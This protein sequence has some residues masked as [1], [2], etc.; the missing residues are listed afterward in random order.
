MT[1]RISILVQ[2]CVVIVTM[3]TLSL[4]Y[5]CVEMMISVLLGDRLGFWSGLVMDVVKMLHYF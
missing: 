4:V 2:H 5:L 3:E 1:D